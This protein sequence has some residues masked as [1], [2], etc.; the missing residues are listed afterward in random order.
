MSVFDYLSFRQIFD[1]VAA[2]IEADFNDK[3]YFRWVINGEPA[4]IDYGDFV[5]ELKKEN[6]KSSDKRTSEEIV[7]EIGEMVEGLQF[8]ESKVNF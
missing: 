8:V 3:M 7:N 4:G 2:A 1:L 6:A 5:N